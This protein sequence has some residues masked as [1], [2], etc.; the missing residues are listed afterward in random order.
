[1]FGDYMKNNFTYEINMWRWLLGV[2]LAAIAIIVISVNHSRFVF[3]F[4]ITIIILYLLLAEVYI[5]NFYAAFNFSVTEHFITI[6]QGVIVKKQIFV[7]LKRQLVFE[8]VSLFPFSIF[9]AGILTIRSCGVL[10]TLPL[11]EGKKLSKIC[12]AYKND[13][14]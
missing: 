8:K 11:M 4:L 9:N 2:P 14:N 3:P 7:P 13:E 12:E 6:T 5:P 1:M 10:V